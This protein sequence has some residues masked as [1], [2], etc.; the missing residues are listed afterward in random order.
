MLYSHRKEKCIK[1]AAVTSDSGFTSGADGD[2]SAG[3]GGGRQENRQTRNGCHNGGK[4]GHL[5]RT[6]WDPEVE[7]KGKVQEGLGRI[8]TQVVT[9]MQKLPMVLEAMDYAYRNVLEHHA[10]ARCLTDRC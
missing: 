10:N 7:K 4:N 3:R 2:E 9:L 8:A 1:A 6:C 5:A